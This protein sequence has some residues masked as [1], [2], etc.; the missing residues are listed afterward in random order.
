MNLH[1]VFRVC[2]GDFGF[3]GL[4]VLPF[5]RQGHLMFLVKQ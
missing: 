5:G 4:E 3:Q 1:V 2:L